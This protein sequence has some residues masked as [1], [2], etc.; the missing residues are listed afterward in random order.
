MNKE[1]QEAARKLTFNAIAADECAN[2]Q[3]YKVLR[4]FV[5]TNLSQPESLL[6]SEGLKRIDSAWLKLNETNKHLRRAYMK[7]YES[8]L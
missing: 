1:V 4:G 2:A 6:N 7:L 5:S 3:Y 8:N